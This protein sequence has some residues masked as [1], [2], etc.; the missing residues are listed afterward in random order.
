MAKRPQPSP[1]TVNTLRE[2]AP[3]SG[4]HEGTVAT[5]N[6]GETHQHIAHDSDHADAPAHLTTNH[7]VRISD[8]QNSLKAGRRGPTLLEDF[9]LRE[10]IFHFD[11]ERI[12]ERIVHARGS[13]A[14][15]VF[16]CTDPIAELT[17]AAI[18][19]EKGATCP[20]FVRFSTVAGGAGSIDTPRDVRGFA[21]K[22]Y[23]EQGN[24][25]LVG[26]NI[27]VFFIQDAIKFPDLV[28]SVKME[29][30]R[31]YPQAGSAH[32]TF[33]DFIGLMP[34]AMHM[35]MWAM[36][37]R[38]I[39][40]TLRNIEG[41]GVHTFRLVNDKGQSQ[42]V[43]FHWKP[44][45]G[46][47][48]TTWDEAVKIAGADP[49]FHRRDLFEAIDSGNF[50]AWDLGVQVFDEEWAGQQPY[51]VLDATK[52]I[53]EEVLPVRVVGRMT[54]NRNVDNFFAETEQVAFLPTNVVP[55]IDFSND[56]LLQGR[57]FSYMDTQ[58]SRLGTTNFHQIPINAPK[59]PFHNMQRD[60]LMQTLV[61]KGRANYEPNSLAE[62]GEDGGPRECP[63]TGFTSFQARDDSYA[64]DGKLRLRS[65]TF[66][67]HYSQAR[68]FYRSQTENE[69]AHIASALVFELSKVT[70][71]HVRTRVLSRLR[72]IDEDLAKR[73]A[74]G[75]ATE[76]PAAAK[77]AVKP[78]DMDASPALSIQQQSMDTMEGRKVGLLYAEGS[79][80]AMIE[81]L[82]KDIEAKGAT[83]FTVAPKVGEIRLKGGTMKADGQLAG[84]PSV[85]F[86]AV[87][88]T[89]P[90]DAAE[91][92]SKDAGAVQWF[93]DA[94]VHCKTVAGCPGTQKHLF[95]K[96]NVEPGEGVCLPEEFVSVGT[97]R[98]WAREPTVRMLA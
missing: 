10:K 1:A 52:L 8:N 65:E 87:V 98:H 43:K 45:L 6:G 83:V 62:A 42:F 50:P 78:I 20:V 37:D 2:H 85:L 18:L 16:E 26:N 74:A 9:V 82:K 79:D 32:D 90:M 15:G 89:M 55:G 12:P 22:F 57:L 64:E 11:H 7:G 35:I 54:L 60:G 29:A 41:F 77:P 51:D 21:V 58:K 31:G 92:L 3:G 17:S 27:P 75:L 94:Y 4:R 73:V 97:K 46:L 53:P 44:V 40:R 76:L 70:L 33:W 25:D 81:K 59:C 86:D 28:H 14:H 67:D 19:S 49:D 66:A 48:S 71:E 95:P 84:S 5:G 80:K 63:E 23:T 96:A 93:A 61:P 39:P 13:G 91:K 30:D 72:N 47:E 34:E 56:P 88:A 69:Q 68:L 38:G 24:W 36:S